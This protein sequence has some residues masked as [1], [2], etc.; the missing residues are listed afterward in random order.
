[1]AIKMVNTVSDTRANMADIFKNVSKG[2]ISE[3]LNKATNEK[4]IL[5]NNKMLVDLLGYISIKNI[6]EYDQTLK[7][8]SCYNELIPQLY[9]EGATEDQAREHMVDEAIDFA[10]DYENNMEM[11]AA[12]FNGVQ[13]FVL[14]NILLHVNDR[15]RVKEILKVG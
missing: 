12:V 9:G 8:Y 2:F 15:K 13:Q 7:V 6:C 4:I 5:L 1:M 10:A 3:T 11:Y 14:G